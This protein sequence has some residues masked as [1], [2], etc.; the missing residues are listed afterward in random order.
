MILQTARKKEK[1]LSTRKF[2]LLIAAVA[3]LVAMVAWF[4]PPIWRVLVIAAVAVAVWR[5]GVRF[6]VE[7]GKAYEIP[8]VTNLHREEIGAL[9][10]GLAKEGR[11]QCQLSIDELNRVKDLL[12]EAIDQLIASFGTMNTY[13]Q[14]QRDL[15]LAIATGMTGS[16]EQER[17]VNFSSFVLDTSK[18]MESFVETTVTTSKISMRLVETIDTISTEVNAILSILGEIE[19]IAKQTNLLALNAAIEAARAG[20]AGRG[21]A[22]VA[23]EV[24][25]L[26]QRT[27]QFSHEIRGHMDQVHGSLTS[28]HESIYSVASMDMNFAL[29]SK[30]RVQETMGLIQAIN[31][32]MAEAAQEIDAY[33]GKVGTEVNAAVTALQFQDMTTQLVG[34]AQAR[35]EAL[36]DAAEASAAAFVDAENVVEGLAKAKQRMEALAE[37]DRLRSNPVKQESM[38]SGDIELF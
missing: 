18:T 9:M 38:D 15:A 37:I 24:R 8:D 17:G 13:I 12:R 29:T 4:A 33:A 25:A 23:D 20:E 36:G 21:F 14:A 2:A 1:R 3:L 16:D 7:Q 30:Q 6:G 28:A 34:H 22:V 10:N 19:A 26:S 31:T 35:I 27:N 11:E 32:R 5:I